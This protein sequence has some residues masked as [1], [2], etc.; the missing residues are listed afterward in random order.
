MQNKFFRIKFFTGSHIQIKY[1]SLLFISMIIPIAIIG[2]SLYYFIFMFLSEQIANPV[3]TEYIIFPVIK[4]VN[5]MLFIG[6]PP[7]LILLLIWGMVLSYHF[8]GPI[9]R[10][11]KE[12]EDVLKDKKYHHRIMIRKGDDIKP[13]SDAI[14]NLLEKLEEKNK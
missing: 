12:L 4:K 13:I 1:L 2:F 8:A 9:K 6:I 11:E 5:T 14:N 3:Y 7:L 10:L